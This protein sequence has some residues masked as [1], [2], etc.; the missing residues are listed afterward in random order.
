MP[1]FLQKSITYLSEVCGIVNVTLT[2]KSQNKITFKVNQN[3][4]I[5]SFRR[6]EK[7]FGQFKAYP[8]DTSPNMSQIDA[9]WTV[10]VGQHII[11]VTELNE[12]NPKFF[13]TLLNAHQYNPGKLA[14]QLEKTKSGVDSLMKTP[15][16]KN[17]ETIF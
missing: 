11:Y 6:M 10:G 2:E 7:Q 14:T 13:V 4:F 1:N 12:N 3:D 16:W 15:E 17:M 5:D 9:V 8:V